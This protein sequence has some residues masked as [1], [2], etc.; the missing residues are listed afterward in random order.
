MSKALFIKGMSQLQQYPPDVAI[1]FNGIC[2]ADVRRYLDIL[3]DGFM[4]DPPAIHHIRYIEWAARA[5]DVIAILHECIGV[6]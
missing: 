6:K 5:K 4:V 2:Q 3:Y 1:A